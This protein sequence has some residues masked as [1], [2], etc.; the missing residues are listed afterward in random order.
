M[1]LLNVKC[2]VILVSLLSWTGP[3][4]QAAKTEGL[5]VVGTVTKIYQL[6]D[7]HSL[8]NWAVVA[9]VDRVV[10]GEFTG[11]SFTF[12]VHS[13]ARAGLQVGQTYTIKATRTAEGYLVNEAREGS[14]RI[15]S[16]VAAKECLRY[17]P[18]V[19]TLTGTLRSQVFPGPPNYE[20]VKRG[21]RKETATILTLFAHACTTDKDSQDFN[22]PE[23][24]IREVQLLVMNDAHWKIIRR[25]MGKRA[26]LT[27]TLFHAHTGHHLTRVLID[28]TTISAGG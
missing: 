26:T 27:G 16:T 2:I 15:H 8:K 28:V 12:V 20:S 6:A 17:G 11:T 7:T 5:V 24:D 13:P 4:L 18:T 25:L 14:I 21:D 10:S 23:T 1:K 19:V 9:N 3:S 22:D